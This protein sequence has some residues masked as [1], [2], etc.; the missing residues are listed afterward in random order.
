M[1]H[2]KYRLNSKLLSITT[3]DQVV[4][5]GTFMGDIYKF[6][7]FDHAPTLHL[8]LQQPISAI[9]P[10]NNTLIIGTWS[11]SIYE[12]NIKMLTFGRNIIKALIVFNKNIIVSESNFIHILDLNYNCVSKVDLKCKVLC[13]D[14]HKNLLVCGTNRSHFVVFDEDLRKSPSV[15][16]SKHH[17]SILGVVHV[18][19]K[20]FSCSADKTIICDGEIMYYG[21]N[22]VHAITENAF[23]DGKNL[24][25]NKKKVFGHNDNIS[26]IVEVNDY[27][28]SIGLDGQIIFIKMI[29]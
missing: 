23:G 16:E 19:D 28:I 18:G 29:V 11:G 1:L 4:Y 24:Y 6:E 22:W 17:T 10:Y 12:N 27:V 15:V 20:R 21:E 25:V 26:G 5:I 13:F 8:S 9:Y 7:T 2:Y 14:I 3:T